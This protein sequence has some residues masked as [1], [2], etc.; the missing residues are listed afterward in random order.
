MLVTQLT[1]T[2]SVVLQQP[3]LGQHQGSWAAQATGHQL[4]LLLHQVL[5]EATTLQAW[6]HRVP[7]VAAGG[8]NAKAR[9]QR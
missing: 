4:L 6:G 5:S 9:G 3:L 8:G 2:R 7:T 1:W